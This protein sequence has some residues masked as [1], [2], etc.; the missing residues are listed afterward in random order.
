MNARYS[1]I[2]R[3]HQSSSFLDT[4]HAFQEVDGYITTEAM[5]A[6]ADAYDSTPSRIYE[7]ASFYSMIRFTPQP[8]VTI[9][10]CRSA[11]CHVAGSAAVIEALEKTLGI[12]MGETTADNS[13]RLEYV[14]C[15]GQCQES[16]ALLVNGELHKNLTPETAVALVREGK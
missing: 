11:P 14:E 8:D 16:P 2:I 6:L 5:E 1:E 12:R 15:L 13:F 9:Q 3:E 10:I 4:L 7:T